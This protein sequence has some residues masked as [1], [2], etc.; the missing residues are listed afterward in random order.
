[1]FFSHTDQSQECHTARFTTRWTDGT[2]IIT[3]EGELDASNAEAFAN[4]VDEC[5][6]A[7]TH[8]VLDLS[9]LRFFGTAEIGRAHV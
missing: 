5:S 8:L 4:H 3:V 2:G 7:G 9:P 1:M 6:A